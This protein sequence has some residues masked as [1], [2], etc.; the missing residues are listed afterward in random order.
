MLLLFRVTDS[1]SAVK[2]LSRAGSLA[3]AICSPQCQD[4][5]C[6]IMSFLRRVLGLVTY[7]WGEKKKFLKFTLL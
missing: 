7:V 3:A 4:F 6:G 1:H 5:D 2:H